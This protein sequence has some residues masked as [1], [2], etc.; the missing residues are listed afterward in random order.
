MSVC[1]AWRCLPVSH[2]V[3]LTYEPISWRLGLTLS[4][5][6]LLFAGLLLWWPR[7]PSAAREVS[8]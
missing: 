4:V 5:V 7:P 6:S 1:V 2:E 3:E 8:R